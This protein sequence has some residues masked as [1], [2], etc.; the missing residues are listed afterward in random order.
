MKKTVVEFHFFGAKLLGSSFLY[1]SN[2]KSNVRVIFNLE[3]V[4]AGPDLN[5]K[6]RSYQLFLTLDINAIGWTYI[7]L[8]SVS[9]RHILLP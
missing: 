5:N 7:W 9:D 8:F 2:N 3:F 1:N 4:S 6:A